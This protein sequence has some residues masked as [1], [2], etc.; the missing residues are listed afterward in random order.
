MA[1]GTSA[2]PLAVTSA[3]GRDDDGTRHHCAAT[4][5]EEVD[6]RHQCEA[7]FDGKCKQEQKKKRSVALRPAARKIRDAVEVSEYEAA[8]AAYLW[9]YHG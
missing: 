5:R 9:A 2:K 1:V 7:T 8:S 6:F 4:G 3:T